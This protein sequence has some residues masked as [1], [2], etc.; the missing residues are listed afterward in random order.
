MLFYRF[1]YELILLEIKIP[2]PRGEQGAYMAN[3]RGVILKKK[4]KKNR[5]NEMQIRANA[6]R[7]N[8]AI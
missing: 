3:G 1:L 8:N 7:R 2:P 4:I 6:K 5:A